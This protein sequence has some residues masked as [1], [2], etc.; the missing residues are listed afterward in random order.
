MGSSKTF[1]QGP[2][3]QG[4]NTNRGKESGYSKG[5]IAKPE[6]THMSGGESLRSGLKGSARNKSKSGRGPVKN[7]GPHGYS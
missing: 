5:A 2:A 1:R 6:G 3:W 4:N 7:S